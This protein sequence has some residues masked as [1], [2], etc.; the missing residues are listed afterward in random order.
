MT[1][2]GGQYAGAVQLVPVVFWTNL[3]IFPLSSAFC[4]G[5]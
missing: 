1:M 4:S 3:S 2:P 5:V